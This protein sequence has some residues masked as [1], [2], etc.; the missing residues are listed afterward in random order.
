MSKVEVEKWKRTANRLATELD[1]LWDKY[2]VAR[3]EADLAWTANDGMKNTL[4]VVEGQR[5]FLKKEVERLE[6]RLRLAEEYMA[7][8]YC[9]GL[10]G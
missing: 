8:K 6:E 9:K 1:D 4:S 3:E 5:D 7:C 10:Y 2:D